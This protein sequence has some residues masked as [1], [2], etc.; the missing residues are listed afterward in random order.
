MGKPEI[1]R[2][3]H[4]RCLSKHAEPVLQSKCN[5]EPTSYDRASWALKAIETFA[6]QT[7]LDIDPD[8]DGIE[9]A[10]GDLLG[11]LMHLCKELDIDFYDMLHKGEGYFSFE[12]QEA[13][14]DEQAESV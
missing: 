13:P 12:T 8:G 14:A 11:D 4:L 3:S 6:D 10:M 5:S 9:T 2:R 1:E 7:G